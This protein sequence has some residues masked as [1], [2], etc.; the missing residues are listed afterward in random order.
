MDRYIIRSR[1]AFDFLQ[2]VAFIL[3]VSWNYNSDK[4]VVVHA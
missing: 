2:L 3:M 1:D 4:R